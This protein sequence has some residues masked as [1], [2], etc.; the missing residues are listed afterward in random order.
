MNS[1]L[2]G[3]W[4]LK[5][6]VVLL[7]ALAAL[8]FGQRALASRRCVAWLAAFAVL[9]LLPLTFVL[10][11]RWVLTHERTAPAAVMAPVIIQEAEEEIPQEPAVLPLAA[12][13]PAA[14]PPFWKR[15]GWAGPLLAGMWL[16]GVAGILGR[17][18][19]GTWQLRRLRK[20][21]VPCVDSRV[22]AEMSRLGGGRRVQLLESA[23]IQ[24]PLT[25]GHVRPVLVLPVVFRQW[26]DD[27]LRAALCHEV[28]HIR[29]RDASARLFG[30]LVAAVYWP[31]FLVWIGLR[32]WR[33][34]QE[35]AADDAVL[36]QGGAPEGYARQLL[37]AA[38]AAVARPGGWIPNPAVAMARAGSLEARLAAIMNPRRDRCLSGARFCSGVLVFAIVGL[39]GLGGVGLQ[40]GPADLSQGGPKR[41][42]INPTMVALEIRWIEVAPSLATGSQA[43]LTESESAE[44]LR[45]WLK[46]PETVATSFPRCVTADGHPLAIRLGTG[47]SSTA[48]EGLE[49]KVLPRLLPANK[50]ELD[51]H[52]A[53]PRNGRTETFASTVVVPLGK[54]CIEKCGVSPS[55]KIR[56]LVI[57]PEVVH[58]QEG[59]PQVFTEVLPAGTSPE[60]DEPLALSTWFVTAPPGTHKSLQ[61]AKW[62][63]VGVGVSGVTQSLTLDKDQ[64]ERLLERLRA[65]KGAQV[66]T[67]PRIR[68]RLNHRS[69]IRSVVNHPVKASGSG[70]ISYLPIGQVLSILPER[71]AAGYTMDVDLTCS[72]IVGKEVIRGDDFP[73]VSS[74][75]LR[76][77]FAVPSGQSIV[78]MLLTD[79]AGPSDEER[80][81]I[82]TPEAA[83]SSGAGAAA[84]GTPEGASPVKLTADR[85]VLNKSTEVI[86]YTGNAEAV[87]GGWVIRGDSIGY[88]K[89]GNRLT[90]EGNALASHHGITHIGTADTSKLHFD[91]ETGTF[92]TTGPFRTAIKK[93][94]AKAK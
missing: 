64:T 10:K 69:E 36:R 84:L 23:F 14:E 80:M 3:E 77:P 88:D 66:V 11:P 59:T 44:R 30:T 78:V 93:D 46:H 5:S 53:W 54:S 87:M 68:S 63:P 81:L 16:A 31:N 1:I 85:M 74:R 8:A 32:R 29:R 89:R 49:M 62:L 38:R 40:G 91:L 60:D 39:A 12:P 48:A 25:W 58:S 72:Q 94:P 86:T 70:G 22:A 73:I 76:A 82:I 55:G 56:V 79:P 41:D 43:D 6:V 50:V 34:A 7:I 75:V 33:M 90:V 52:A 17:R 24:V 4:M 18:L 27:E 26:S 28:E 42:L 20:T 13:A 9:A 35:E 47:S 71:S 15:P 45:S 67:W 2:V 65:L 19:V 83:S 51:L 37:K 92:K 21:C 61:D 57:N